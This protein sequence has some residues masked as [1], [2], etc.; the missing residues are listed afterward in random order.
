MQKSKPKCPSCR[1]AAFRTAAGF[2]CS[3]CRRL[4]A[5]RSNRT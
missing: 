4:I 3:K 1:A 5:V 2:V